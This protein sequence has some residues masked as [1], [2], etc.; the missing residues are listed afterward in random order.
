LDR[1]RRQS[2]QGAC[3]ISVIDRDNEFAKANSILYNRVQ[4]VLGI[5]PNHGGQGL[6]EY[7]HTA[8]EFGLPIHT[9]LGGLC[10]AAIGMV[11]PKNT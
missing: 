5:D 10:E 3:K 8:Q 9:S 7:W 6:H 4:V 2:S 11:L 1:T